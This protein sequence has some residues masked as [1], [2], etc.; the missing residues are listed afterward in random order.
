M[1]AR[2]QVTNPNPRRSCSPRMTPKL[3]IGRLLQMARDPATRSNALEHGSRRTRNKHLI[4]IHRRRPRHTTLN[5][6]ACV[7]QTQDTPSAAHWGLMTAYAARGQ[8]PVARLCLTDS[9]GTLTPASVAT[10][11]TILVPPIHDPPTLSRS[12]G[13]GWVNRAIAA[14]G[15]GILRP[16]A[17]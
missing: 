8:W 9:I 11:D 13:G 10:Y 1:R 12:G 17:T 4:A 5:I 3:Q 2:P 14:Q 6:Q 16:L 7:T 15:L